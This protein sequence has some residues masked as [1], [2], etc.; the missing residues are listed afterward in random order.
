MLAAAI[1][2]RGA[3]EQLLHGEPHPG[4]LIRAK[5]GPLFV[6]LETC[7]GGP[8]EFDL[9]HAPEAVSARYPRIDRDLLGDCRLLSLAM[10]AAWRWDREDEF[11][12]GRRMGEELLG[13]LRAALAGRPFDGGF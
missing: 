9:A 3:P 4:N 8:V 2:K 12:D 10:V 5:E 7:C 1:A 6:D 11:P 13:T